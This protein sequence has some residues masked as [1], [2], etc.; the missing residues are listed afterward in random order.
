MLNISWTDV[1]SSQKLGIKSIDKLKFLFIE[2]LI[3]I[4]IF[5]N[6][7]NSSFLLTLTNKSIKLIEK[8]HLAG[9]K[10]FYQLKVNNHLILERF[11]LRLSYTGKLLLPDLLNFIFTK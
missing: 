11:I 4:T 5:K 9:R 2:S 1:I 10:L 6:L 3:E 8:V 7:N